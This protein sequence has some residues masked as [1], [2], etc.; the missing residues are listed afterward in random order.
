MELLFAS[1]KTLGSGTQV[2]HSLPELA[3]FRLSLKRTRQELLERGDD[4]TPLMPLELDFYQMVRER[5]AFFPDC[6]INTGDFWSQASDEA[7]IRLIKEDAD[8]AEIMYVM[9]SPPPLS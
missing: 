8:L 5:R 7:L 1:D 6:K 4:I 3:F 9:F 2:T